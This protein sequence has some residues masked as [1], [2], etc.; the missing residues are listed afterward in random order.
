MLDTTRNQ[1]LD[2]V[3]E[4][5]IER[6]TIHLESEGAGFDP[7][8]LTHLKQIDQDLKDLWEKIRRVKR[9]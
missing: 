6:H 2:Q 4:K 9:S 7:E 3:N 5:I 8:R 1:L